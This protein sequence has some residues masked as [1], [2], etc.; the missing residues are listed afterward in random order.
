MNHFQ[1]FQNAFYHY[2]TNTRD[3]EKFSKIIVQVV[4]ISLILK[5]A[6][7]E[8]ASSAQFCLL[9]LKIARF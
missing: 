3:F 4:W 6:I 9:W 7:A 1:S 5:K 8:V 2:K